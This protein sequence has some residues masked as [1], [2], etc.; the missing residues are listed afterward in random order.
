MTD[1]ANRPAPIP[2]PPPGGLAANVLAA[3]R[4]LEAAQPTP[5]MPTGA[6]AITR[7]NTA[8]TITVTL[9]IQ[10]ERTPTGEV[11]TIVEYAR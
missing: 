10:V 5:G 9:P 6:V 4:A 11:T 2:T 1:A 7:G 3:A 8:Y